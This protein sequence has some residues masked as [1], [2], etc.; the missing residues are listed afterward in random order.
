MV[1]MGCDFTYQNAR[2]NF[3]SVDRLIEYM[4]AH[5]QNVTLFYSTPGMYLD[6]LKAQDIT[7]PVKYDDMFPYA[8]FDNSYW[9]GYFTSRANAKKY[10]RDGSVNLHATMKLYAS[11]M[12]DQSTSNATITQL[13]TQREAMLDTMGVVQHHDGVTGTAKQHVAD[14][15]NF[16]LFK[17]I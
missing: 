17:S 3:L 15:Y 9:T 13:L 8:D 11:K 12:V 14:D 6:A 5:M 10:I 16:R 1:T 7:W 4:N 2:M